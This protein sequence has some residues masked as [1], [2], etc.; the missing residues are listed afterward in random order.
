MG[1]MAQKL[2]IYYFSESPKRNAVLFLLLNTVLA[3]GMYLFMT[4]YFAIVFLFRI[5]RVSGLDF[6]F[7]IPVALLLV[8]LYIYACLHLW[9]RVGEMFTAKHTARETALIAV[10]GMIPFALVLSTLAPFTFPYLFSIWIVFFGLAGFFAA[11]SKEMYH[12]SAAMLAIVLCLGLLTLVIM[13]TNADSLS[14]QGA[15][16]IFSIVQPT[17]E[18]AGAESVGPISFTLASGS[19]L[20]KMF[21]TTFLRLPL[22]YI[23]LI[24]VTSM[25]SMGSKRLFFKHSPFALAEEF[26][27]A[28]E[29]EEAERKAEKEERKVEKK[30]KSKMII[31]ERKRLEIMRKTWLPPCL[32]Q[33]WDSTLTPTRH[34][35]SAKS[36]TRCLE[37]SLRQGTPHRLRRAQRTGT[38]RR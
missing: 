28:M 22:A 10:V 6:F 27:S 26:E 17:S 29:D 23:L 13:F 21:S 8:S 38:G 18:I 37:R 33:H 11:L 12:V 5:H 20:E 31:R 34:G 15:G 35:T 24:L 32:Q 19:T 1:L 16:Y 30:L 3:V 4:G 36:T 25:L 7:K 2:I 9:F 14:S